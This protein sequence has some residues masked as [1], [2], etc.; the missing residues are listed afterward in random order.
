MADFL[1][2]LS[3]FTL[4]DQYIMMSFI[5]LTAAL[6][7]NGVAGWIALKAQTDADDDAD[8]D[9]NKKQR[10]S[11]DFSNVSEWA[12]FA[13]FVAYNLYFGHKC[14]SIYSKNMERLGDKD[15]IRGEHLANQP[16]GDLHQSGLLARRLRREKRLKKTHGS[17]RG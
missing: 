2:H 9:N 14:W 12:L 17:A 4:C 1:P 7:Q 8:D 5:F 6:L 11:D 15:E 13:T 16:R 10:F 3:Y